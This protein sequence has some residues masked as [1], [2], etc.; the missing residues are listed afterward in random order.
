MTSEQCNRPCYYCAKCDTNGGVCPLDRDI[1]DHKT[2]EKNNQAAFLAWDKEQ[3]LAFVHEY[4]K[5]ELI[6]YAMSD[7]EDTLFDRILDVVESYFPA[8]EWDQIHGI[9]NDLD[10]TYSDLL[11]MSRD[12]RVSDEKFY[13]RIMRKAY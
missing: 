8:Y 6:S 12:E 10:D 1:E 9:D 5:L 4:R 3:R 13:E 2:M 7:D 11:D